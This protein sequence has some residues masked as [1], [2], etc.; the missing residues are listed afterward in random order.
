MKKTSKK[1]VKGKELETVDVGCAIIEKRGRLLIAQRYPGTTLGGY[2]EFPGGKKRQGESIEDCLVR[3]V[4]EELMVWIR[5]KRFFA[6][7]EIIRFGRKLRL[8][9]YLCDWILGDPVARDCYA[10]RWAE[11]RRLR[12]YQFPPPDDAVLKE[13]VSRR[14]VYFSCRD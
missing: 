8:H 12:D 5:P 1:K 14:W 4:Y 3:E 13:L 11:P 6:L 10:F 2:W 9:F 7:N